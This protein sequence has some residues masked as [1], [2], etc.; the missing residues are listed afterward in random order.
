[1][2]KFLLAAAGTLLLAAPAQAAVP[3][4]NLAGVPSTAEIDVAAAT[5]AKTARV[6]V[7][8]KDIEP[9]KGGALHTQ[10]YSRIASELAARGM[11][12]VF[13][14]MR[15][16]AWANGG[17]G[18]NVPPTDP[19]T[20]ASFVQRFAATPGIQGNVA[21][22]EIWN[23]QDEEQ[24]WEQD[25]AAR[26][27]TYAAMVNAVGPAVRAGDPAAKAILGPTTGN[28]YAFLAALYAAGIDKSAY[29]VIA[30]HTD[31]ACL[32][33]G[34]YSFYRDA[35]RIARFTFLGYRE[36]RATALAHGDD[37]PIW[38]TELGWTTTGDKLC[39]RGMWAGQKPAGV[40]EAEQAAFLQQA[41]NCLAEDP[42]VEVAQWFTM[43]DNPAGPIEE[44]R[45]YGLVT[46]AGTPKPS[47][48]AFRAVAAHPAHD[49]LAE[50][51]GDFSGPQV[52]IHQPTT[53]QRFNGAL[54]IRAS[55]TGGVARLTFRADG[56]KIRNF[57][58]TAAQDGKA[59]ELLWQ[60]AKLLKPG[61]HT[62]TVEA[63]DANGN[64]SSASTD[65][66]KGGAKAT[67]P[68][69]MKL[70]RKVA[71]KGRTCSLSGRAV[72]NGTTKLDGKVQ[73]LWQLRKGRTYTTLHKVTKAAVRSFTVRQRV[74]KAGQWRV[75]VR[76]LGMAPYKPSKT[77]VKTFRVR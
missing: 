73:I 13:V 48:A 53:G 23:E 31:T 18:E 67:I 22:Y 71:C 72:A 27:A 44:L 75:Q 39:E 19:A 14:V 33:R 17:A 58:G 34:P 5:G 47:L 57:T 41:F 26:P 45:H 6:F 4:V 74:R 20:M 52:T 7:L 29:D 36:V 63:V 61:A 9:V 10:S 40:D 35:G 16:P 51:C 42:Y 65:V 77:V 56:V 68:S 32:D 66:I 60:G 15:T 62:I 46:P 12:A 49:P 69:V 50:A 28:N 37:K 76:Y 54:L 3:G 8:W 43:R 2:R 25:P 21:G 1:M 38:M 70:G 11:K 64:A 30:V 24:F 55:A 59:T